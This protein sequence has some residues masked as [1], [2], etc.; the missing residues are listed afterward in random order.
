MLFYAGN[1]S[2]PVFQI[3]IGLDASGSLYATA[4]DGSL[5]GNVG[6][7][8]EYVHITLEYE[9]EAREYRVYSDGALVGVSGYSY[10]G[11][12]NHEMVGSVNIGSV[13]TT[14]AN[15]Y[16]DNICFKTYKK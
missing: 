13:S 10:G 9:W 4:G 5:I 3:T 2:T 8:G 6:V 14:E 11:T 7:R 12:A 16:L 15:Y 1:T